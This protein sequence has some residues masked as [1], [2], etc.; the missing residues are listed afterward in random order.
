M[1]IDIEQA[2]K[3]AKELVKVRRR[4]EARRRTARDRARARIPELAGHGARTGR[5]DGRAGRPRADH[6][7]DLALELLAAA[8]ELRGDPVGPR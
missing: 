1:K 5:A 2:R 3:R 7:P 8:P 6:R 4:G